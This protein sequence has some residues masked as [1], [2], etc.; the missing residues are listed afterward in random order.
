MKL[1]KENDTFYFLSEVFTWGT[2]Q[3]RHTVPSFGPSGIS[4]AWVLSRW[5]RWRAGWRWGWGSPA[6]ACKL[7]GRSQS[8]LLQ[9]CSVLRLSLRIVHWVLVRPN[10]IHLHLYHS[11][12]VDQ[13]TW[14]RGPVVPWFVHIGKVRND[15]KMYLGSSGAVRSGHISVCSWTI[16]RWVPSCIWRQNRLRK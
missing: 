14:R 16:S 10:V 5:A 4:A 3:C 6:R 7:P 13:R 1:Q 15:G 11:P 8:F 9:H 2:W 12:S